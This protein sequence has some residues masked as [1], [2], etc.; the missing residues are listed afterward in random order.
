VKW[1]L[2]VEYRPEAALYTGSVPGLNIKVEAVSEDE[3][4]RLLKEAIPLHLDILNQVGEAPKPGSAKIMEFEI[5]SAYLPG[6]KRRPA[7]ARKP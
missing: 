3:A 2:V 6:R 5:D 7:P 1:Q 4:F